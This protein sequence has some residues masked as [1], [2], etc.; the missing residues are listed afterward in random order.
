LRKKLPDIQRQPLVPSVAAPVGPSSTL[1]RGS[2][3]APPSCLDR[4]SLCWRASGRNRV[5]RAERDFA[6][7]L[8]SAALRGR[9]RAVT[10]TVDRLNR[11]RRRSSTPLDVLA[12]LTLWLVVVPPSDLRLRRGGVVPQR[13]DD[14][15]LLRAR[16]SRR[17]YPYIWPSAV[18]GRG[19]GEHGRLR[20]RLSGHP[21]GPVHCCGSNGAR[22]H[23]AGGGH[24][25]D[26][27]ALHRTSRAR[28]SGHVAARDIAVRRSPAVARP[29]PSEASRR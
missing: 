23:G 13:G 19:D 27:I 4:S 24:G 12:L 25:P 18:V 21:R 14:R 28:P 26:R 22:V 6:L 5:R 10:G 2:A 1:A 15:V 16:C 8:P 17:Q 29:A 7:A 3:G 11:Y 20:R 9:L